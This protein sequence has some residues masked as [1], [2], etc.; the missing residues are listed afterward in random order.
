M[1]STQGAV[2]GLLHAQRRKK[3]SLPLSTSPEAGPDL[4]GHWQL[5]TA[6]TGEPCPA[7]SQVSSPWSCLRT[8]LQPIRASPPE[9]DPMCQT[10]LGQLQ[11]SHLSTPGFLSQHVNRLPNANL[12]LTLCALQLQLFAGFLYGLGIPT[13]ALFPCSHLCYKPHNGNQ[14]EGRLWKVSY[15]QSL[16]NK[17]N[18]GLFSAAVAWRELSPPGPYRMWLRYIREEQL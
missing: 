8:H 2:L 6:L 5:N 16:K 10:C 11:G 18:K 15:Y 4:S 1:H 13:R 17:T 14:D 12:S 3:A 7:P 9:G